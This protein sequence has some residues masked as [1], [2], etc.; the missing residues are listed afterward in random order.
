MV[1]YGS[2]I[3]LPLTGE[4]NNTDYLVIMAFVSLWDILGI[5]VKLLSS[6]LLCWKAGKMGK[7]KDLRDFEK[8]QIVMLDDW[9]R[10]SPKLQLLWGVPGLQWS[11]PK[12]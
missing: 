5:K 9:V 10:A 3:T 2:A 1:H 12:W 7:R 6:K 11:V 4:V 8:C